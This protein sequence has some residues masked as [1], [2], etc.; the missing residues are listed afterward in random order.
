MNLRTFIIKYT[1][2]IKWQ[3]IIKNTLFDIIHQL[4]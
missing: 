3:K 1:A 2:H 4:K